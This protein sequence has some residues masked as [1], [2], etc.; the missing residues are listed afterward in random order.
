MSGPFFG[1]SSSTMR[2]RTFLTLLA[3]ACNR[4]RTITM[5]NNTQKAPRLPVLF[6][7]HGS[8]MNA[9]EDNQWS[10]AFHAVGAALPLPRAILSV[11]AHWYLPGTYVTGNDPPETIHDFG[12]F[13]QPL[14]DMQYPAPGSVA[15]AHRVVAALG[16]KASVREDWGLDHGTWSVLHHLRPAADIPV[17]QLSIDTRLTPA[18]HLDLARGLRPLREE[19]ILVMGSGNATHNLRQFMRGMQTGDRSIP[20]WS[21]AFDAE[22]ARAAEQHDPEHL[23]RAIETEAGRMSHPSLDHFLPVVYAMGASDE[24]DRVTFPITGFD[25]GLSMRSIQFG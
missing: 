20:P 10:R 5:S 24:H 22:V 1:L 14:F 16:G 17:V 2:R 11:S 23:V 7:G 21:T 19:G 25:G 4:P 12:G 8:P 15:L 9:I 3:A 6:M 18:Q 13:P